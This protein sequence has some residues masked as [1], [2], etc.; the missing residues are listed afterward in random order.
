[1][2]DRRPHWKSEARLEICGLQDLVLVSHSGTKQ[3]N[4]LLL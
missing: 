4:T 3:V 2:H 1:L